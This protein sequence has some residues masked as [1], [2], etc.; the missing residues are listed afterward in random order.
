MKVSLNLL[1]KYV[2]VEDIEPSKIAELVTSAGFEV[3][4]VEKLAY[5][6]NVVIGYVKECS[7]HPDSDH[8]HVCLV[9]IGEGNQTQIVCGAPN[10][11][12]GQKVMVALPGCV[13]ANDL[14]I[15]ESTIRGQSSNGMIC[16]LSEIGIDARFQSEAQKAG[17]EVL[18]AD[19]PLG[20][21]ALSYL[22]LE[23]SILDISLTPNRADCMAI[24]S[25]AYEVGA[26]LNREVTL[27]TID[28][29]TKGKG[30]ISVHIETEKC[31]YFGAKLVKG[32]K[33]KESPQ[34][35]KTA[36][37]A[38]G[39]KPIN[40]V[41][42][43]SNYVM[44]E[45]GQPIHMYDYDKLKEKDFVIKTGFNHEAT[46]LD[47]QKYLLN[48]EDIIVST[49]GDVGCIA[50]VMGSNS[51][52]IDDETTNII[53]EVAT[54]NG[55]SLR[56][57][58]R[59]L[60][61]LTDASQ[62]FIKNVIDTNSSERTMDRVASLLVELANATEVYDSVIAGN[63]F[64]ERT[65]TLRD[66]RVNDLLGTRIT[67][68]E[69][70]DI[71]NRLKFNFKHVDGM[72][73]VKVPSHRHDITL[74]ADLVEEVARL[75]G[76]DHIPSTLPIMS[77]TTGQ[78]TPTQQRKYMIKT[79]LSNM[80]LQEVITYTLVSP[81]MMNDFNQFHKNEEVRLMSPL[82]EERS[83]TR[84][85]V[86][87]S[88]LQTISYNQS[89]SNKDVNIFEI[90]NTYTQ[91]CE[92]SVLG[93]A[94]SGIYH[95]NKWQKVSK[96]A[97]FYL[98]KGFVEAIFK[99]L[100]IEESRYIL[101]R[102]E[103]NHPYLHPGRSGYLYINKECIGYVGQ[104]HPNMEKKYDVDTTY[105]AELNLDVICHLKTK[106]LKF[107]SI[108]Q[109]PSVSRDLALVV[110]ANEEAYAMIRTIKRAS[111]RLVKEAEI[112]DVY[113]GEHVEVGKK[114]IA[115]NLVFQD[116]NKT[117]SENE[118]NDCLAAILIALDKEHS[119]KLRA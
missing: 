24:I 87:P 33:T 52:K 15:K 31:P 106:K 56:K 98:L 93:I 86:I 55:T 105:V 20:E 26:V 81:N 65:V 103:A 6:T 74:E 4:G 48:S 45:T 71:F 17:I 42:D 92:I 58:A 12:A 5:G 46:L 84:K 91:E 108:A 115:I 21:N 100:G 37:M 39:I 79:M 27:P 38:S 57:T 70:T 99:K 59:R 112:F 83:V 68:E 97:D 64:P 110:D 2:K 85:S 47:G 25:F 11:E 1:N 30:D 54:F 113:Q 41:V 14:K 9:E 63:T 114:S 44:L 116:S 73:E 32:V 8:L 23:D 88:M 90:A 18:P 104:I 101:Q 53:I 94:C 28:V 82:G 13:L 7:M 3:E 109:Y 22:G 10:V 76:Y 80:G 75:Y 89:H 61:L 36:L 40:N 16:S 111:K 95:S 51:T 34:W 69:I 117:L 72:F 107:E 43:I 118:I 35:L 49:D 119:A 77:S 102:V 66:N 29:D 19:A 62:R 67:V 60:N 78:R 96:T 50:G